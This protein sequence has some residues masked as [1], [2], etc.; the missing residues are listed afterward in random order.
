MSDVTKWKVHGPV[1][2]LRTEFATWNLNQE[3][4]QQ[5]QSFTETSFRPDGAVSSSDTNN[6]D[7]SIVHSRWLYDDAARL[8][9]SNSWYNDGPIDRVLYSYD[10][11][12]RHVRTVQLSH[13]G[14]RTDSE[15]C[16]YDTGGKKTKVR[17]L[18]F[19]GA[20]VDAYGIEG[21]EQAYPAP[22]AAML[23]TTYDERDLPTKVVF[24]DANHNSLR[25]VTF[26]R[27]SAGRLLNEELHAGVDSPFPDLLDKVPPEDREGMAAMLKKVFG[28]TFSSTTYMYDTQG[29]LLERTNGMGSLGAH[30]TTYRYDDHDDPIEET[31]EHRSR[32]ARIDENG[33]VHYSLDRLILQHNH[34]EYRY[35][36]HGNWTERIVSIRPEPNPGFQRSNIERRAITYHAAN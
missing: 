27:D 7:G 30:R 29:R 31:N 26:M 23:T 1:E 10:E 25:Y 33:A 34:F 11:A 15:S 35:D 36:A 17:F 14:T 5:T 18:G 2:T 8:T 12:G 24:H 20:K 13:D 21:S 28:E 32:E 3:K 6:P 9:E 4:W 19:R 16:S 22:G